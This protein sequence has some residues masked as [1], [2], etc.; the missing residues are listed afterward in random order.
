MNVLILTPDRVGSTFLQRY[1]TIIMQAYDYGKPVINLHELTNGL[2]KYHNPNLG[3]EV[4]GKPE[5]ENWG[6]WQKLSE[7]VEI[8]DSADHYKTSRLAL[9]HL[10]NRQ[11]SLADR[12]SLYKYLNDNFYIISARRKNLFEHGISWCITAES[13]HLNVFSHEEKIHVFKDV[14]KRGIYVDTEVM[15]NYLDRYVEYL[16]WVDDH[17]NVSTIFN[18]ERDMPNID[19]FVSRLNIFPPGESAKSWKEIYGI[20]WKEWNSCHYL[21]SD[22]S[23]FSNKVPLLENQITSP[24]GLLAP[25]APDELLT[26]SIPLPALL[27]RNSL[28][29]SNQ[30]F[31][32][33]NIKQ[34]TDVYY[35]IDDLESKK[36]ITSKMPIKL[37]TLAEKALLIKN[38]SECIDAFNLWCKK[39][40]R[41]DDIIDNEELAKK[42]FS[43]VNDWYNNFTKE[44]D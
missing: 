29:I 26:N 40:N 27:K 39:R 5:K 44:Q 25:P 9:Y 16:K 14:Y 7:V 23:G 11:D 37:Q 24:T 6:Y 30:N 41:E 34:Y 12:L 19:Q 17:F 36:I 2:I 31:L 4:V 1:I 35:H 18:Y 42:A 10:I 43:E 20:S 38:F 13:K 21:I 3:M 33:K 28:S 15:T 32:Q 8:L 22:M